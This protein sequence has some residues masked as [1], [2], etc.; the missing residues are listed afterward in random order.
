MKNLL[1]IFFLLPVF[2]QGQEVLMIKGNAGNL[3]LNHTAAAKENFYSVGRMYNISPKEIAPFNNLVLEDG[4]N[5]GQ[6]IKIPLV[7]GNFMQKKSPGTDD[8]V[9]PVYHKL[10]PKETLYQLSVNYNKVPVDL[11]KA[12]NKLTGDAV[13]TGQDIIVGYLKVNKD[14]SALAVKGVEVPV[15]KKLT[16]KEKAALA[17]KENIGDDLKQVPAE[18][19]SVTVRQKS[20]EPVQA[21]AEVN[22]RSAKNFKGGVFKSLYENTGKEETGEAGV[23]KSTSGW[24]DGKYYCLHNSALQGAVVKI[25]NNATGKSIYAK[26]LDVMPDLGQNNGLAI[27]LSNAAGDALGAGMNNFTCTINY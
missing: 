5:I 3:H 26:V 10:G 7:A 4:I 18:S 15:E 17:K 8:V 22:I 20:E 9:I 6:V 1:F 11:L 24:E 23:F 2:A 21:S 13:S 27:R 25:T 16:K 14:Q 19:E 12:W